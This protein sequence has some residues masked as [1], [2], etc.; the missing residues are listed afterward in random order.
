MLRL[1]AALRGARRVARRLTT[2][3][4]VTVRAGPGAGL[5]LETAH[6]SAS[7]QS[8][9]NERPVQDAIARHLGEGETF[10][11]IGAN[12]GFF[13]LIGARIVG[14]RG[15]AIA[16]E[17]LP[18]IAAQIRTNAALNSLDN[19][20]VREQAVGRS[21]GTAELI[22]TRHP[23]GAILAET[24]ESVDEV[25]RASV[26]VVT[27]DE[28][29]A[30]G[31]IRPPALIKLDVEGAELAALEGMRATLAQHRP[32]VVYETDAP[33][34]EALEEKSAALD[35]LLRAL[36]YEIEVLPDSYPGVGWSV[37]HAMATHH[38]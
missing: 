30:A 25:G 22:V 3:R 19:V 17:P 23:G 32:A 1:G 8:G 27:I 33:T 11:D 24:G 35:G 9:R 10:Y 12:V 26:E 15:L 34:S 31:E 36:G 21:S 16:F 2:P 6:A 20:L 18:R 29:I 14:E 28:L 5:R 38:G 4:V 7:Y 37:R 13:A